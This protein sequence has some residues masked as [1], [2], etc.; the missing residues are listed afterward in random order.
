MADVEMVGLE[1]GSDASDNRA[2]LEAL[3]NR[4]AVFLLWPPEGKPGAPFLARTNI[5]RRRLL[6]MVIT[7]HIAAGHLE[8]RLVGSRLEGQMLVLELARRHLG[9]QYRSAIRLRLPPWVKL[10][11]S[12][13]F[14]RTQV[15]NRIGRA[16]AVYFG[17]FR[18]RASA[19]RFEAEAL[20]LFQLRRCQDDL[21]PSAEHPGCIYGEMGKCLRPCQMAVGI[22]EYRGEAARFAEFLRSGGRSLASSAESSRERLSAE[23]NFEGAALMHQR[24]Q[25][26]AEVVSLRDEMC[27]DLRTLN[28]AVVLGSV[29][30][31]A[32]EIGWLREGYWR[33][34]SRLGF[35]TADGMPVSLDARLRELAAPVE[36]SAP[37]GTIERLEQLAVIARWRYSDWCD[38]EM[39]LFEDD[40]KIPWRKLVNAVSRIAQG[41][42]KRTRK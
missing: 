41:P 27:A 15:T 20:D 30:A 28:A 16:P 1:L 11:L 13:P 2:R 6:R 8:Y 33:G 21:V 7:D 40:S 42:A 12:N 23:M 36:A 9:P 34:A 25:R 10:I 24:C 32:V 22:E 4:P 38:G 37:V 39:F 31:N 18:S 3:P 14:P 26:I 17:P 5:L 19:A 29:E 35:L